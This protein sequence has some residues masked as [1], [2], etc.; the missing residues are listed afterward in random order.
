MLVRTKCKVLAGTFALTVGYGDYSWDDDILEILEVDKFAS[1]GVD[2]TPARVTTQEIL[3]LRSNNSGTSTPY[4]YSVA[5]AN[6]LMLYPTPGSGDVVTIYYV[7]R[8]TVLTGSD[9]PTDIP[10][11][12]HKALFLY[13]AAE[14]YND[15]EDSG[16]VQAQLHR[17]MYEA[18]LKE[19]RKSILRMG[20]SRL[21]RAKVGLGGFASHD[22]SADWR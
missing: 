2:Y 17:A 13:A 8:P 22:N 12:W 10:A 19:I 5:G 14:A 18:M 3:S 1:G 4:K 6:L 15:R 16:H 11:Q 20:G 7:P 21:P 9:V